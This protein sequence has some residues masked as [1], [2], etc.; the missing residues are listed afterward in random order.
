MRRYKVEFTGSIIVRADDEEHAIG[1]MLEHV[2]D[3]TLRVIEV[4]EYDE[5]GKDYLNTK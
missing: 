3:A 2:H 5:H 1:E 4:E